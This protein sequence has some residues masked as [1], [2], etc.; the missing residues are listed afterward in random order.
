MLTLLFLL[1]SLIRG[2]RK[3]SSQSPTPVQS[4]EAPSPELPMC[5]QSPSPEPPDL[6]SELSS[7]TRISSESYRSRYSPFSRESSVDVGNES[8]HSV[9]S[10][11]SFSTSSRRYEIIGQ[12]SMDSRASVTS[13]WSSDMSRRDSEAIPEHE[14]D[15]TDSRASFASAGSL[16]SSDGS[17]RHSEGLGRRRRS[18]VRSSQVRRHT[19]RFPLTYDRRRTTGR[20]V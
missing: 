17:R 16:V 9:T 11:S 12:R 3:P 20:F 13:L 19:R 2:L 5:S 10:I 14:V 8:R 1:W 15:S 7:Q 18:S 4:P 6:H